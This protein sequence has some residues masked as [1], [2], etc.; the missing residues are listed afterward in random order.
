MDA[1]RFRVD[2]SQFPIVWVTLPQL[3]AE[4]S[5]DEY[6][7]RMT[8]VS[9][10]GPFVGVFD[11][12]QLRLLRIGAKERAY[13]AQA[14]E[15]WAASGGRRIIKGEAVLV[16]NSF[17]RA[18]VT[19]FLWLREEQPFPTEVFANPEAATSWC[20]LLLAEHGLDENLHSRSA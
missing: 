7:A 14:S 16:M 11:T 20:R 13:F 6:C 9:K 19:G 5:V 3:F 15:R 10:R 12:R 1:Y 17:L 4:A 2:D 18:M 8:E